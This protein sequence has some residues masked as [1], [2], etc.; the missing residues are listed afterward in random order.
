M[1][2]QTDKFE[3]EP[4]RGEGF[5]S[6]EGV[7]C[8]HAV[9]AKVTSRKTGKKI[10]L[11]SYHGIAKTHA[12]RSRSPKGR[13]KKSVEDFLS[14]VIKE[15]DE[16]GA[17]EI[18]I[19]ADLNLVAEEV[20]ESINKLQ[21]Q[22]CEYNKSCKRE[23]CDKR[24]DKRQAPKRVIDYFIHTEGISLRKNIRIH[25]NINVMDHHPL[26]AVFTCPSVPAQHVTPCDTDALTDALPDA[27]NISGPDDGTFDGTYES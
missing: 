5:Q 21:L 19:G 14:L 20:F 16:M 22:E 24:R 13:K 4:W 25:A 3:I 17:E 8:H 26:R 7:D 9:L 12:N 18:L 15:K 2:R 10:L 23:N 27:L 6:G 1:D 11:A